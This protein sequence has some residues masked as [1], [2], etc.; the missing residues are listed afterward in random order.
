MKVFGWF[1][2]NCLK[3]TENQNNSNTNSSNNNSNDN[4]YNDNDNNTNKDSNTTDGSNPPAPSH[5][6]LGGMQD[7]NRLRIV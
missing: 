2:R 4:E 1:C 3:L 7:C 6:S 5:E